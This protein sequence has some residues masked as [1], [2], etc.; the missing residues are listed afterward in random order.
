MNI[1]YECM[2]VQTSMK[3]QRIERLA[4]TA[5]TTKDSWM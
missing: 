5:I 4:L 1:E 3:V 2:L